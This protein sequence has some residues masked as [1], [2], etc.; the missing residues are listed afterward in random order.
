MSPLA[1]YDVAK[2]KHKYIERWTSTTQAYHFT[3]L[4]VS[5]SYF[6]QYGPPLP[7]QAEAAWSRNHDDPPHSEPC[8]GPPGL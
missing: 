3:E 7:W 5:S 8:P 6:H 4:R 1:E 2:S